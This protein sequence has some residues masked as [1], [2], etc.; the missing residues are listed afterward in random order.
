MEKE[1]ILQLLQRYFHA[2]KQR[3]D[4]ATEKFD[5]AIQES[6]GGSRLPHGLQRL[7]KASSELSHARQEMVDAHARLIAFVV[8][9]I[10][11]DNLKNDAVREEGS[12]QVKEARE[13]PVRQAAQTK[14]ARPSLPP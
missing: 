4:A 13:R 7:H 6:S 5:A 10:I 1:E 2:A 11:P 9:G 3:L 8:E 14:H 12:G